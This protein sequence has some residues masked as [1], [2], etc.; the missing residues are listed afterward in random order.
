MKIE[1]PIHSVHFISSRM[2]TVS[3]LILL[4]LICMTQ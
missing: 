2:H 4:P 3:R 1:I